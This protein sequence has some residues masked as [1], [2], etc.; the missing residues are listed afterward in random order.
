MGAAVKKNMLEYPI[1]SLFWSTS[2]G[3]SDRFSAAWD[4]FRI[5]RTLPGFCGM[6]DEEK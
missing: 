4:S 6:V 1:I 3:G 5:E 2:G